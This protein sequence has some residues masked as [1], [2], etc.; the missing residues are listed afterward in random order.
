ML[1]IGI[2]LGELS[3]YLFRSKNSAIRP[4]SDISKAVCS[5]SYLNYSKI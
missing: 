2:M 4:S 5:N 3:T 1:S